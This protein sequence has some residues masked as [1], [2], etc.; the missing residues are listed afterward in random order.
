MA[1]PVSPLLTDLYQLTMLQA[2]FD[3]GMTQTAVFEFFVRRL[4]KA[5]NFLVAAG[6]ADVLSY[7]GELRFSAE[8][9]DW[10]AGHGFKSDFIGHL[11][12]LR[13]TGDVWAMPEGTVFFADE[14][15]LR[16]VAPLP[17]A[18]LVQSP[19]INLLQFQ[20]LIA[21]KAARSVLVAPEKLLVD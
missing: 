8:E 20:T 2:Y 12:Q 15:I 16:V 19:I 11:K 5:R 21:S 9:L 10:L 13:F 1:Q 3:R 14:P 7:L 18:Q 4:P 17:E 6:L